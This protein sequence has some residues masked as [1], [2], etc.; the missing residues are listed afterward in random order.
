MNLREGTRRLALLLS[1]SC[2]LVIFS[3][4]QA[5]SGQSKVSLE[6]GTVTVWLGMPQ[7]QAILDLQKAGYK[8]FGQ[9]DTRTVSIGNS[10]AMIGFKN[11]RLAYATREWYSPGEDEMVA[12]VNA[13]TAL[14]SYSVAPCS[15]NHQDMNNPDGT[16]SIV[17][18]NCG[19]RSLMFTK[20]EAQTREG[21]EAVIEVQERIGLK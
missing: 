21:R 19:E 15:L 8:V 11:G 20:G 1:A 6:V 10:P 9:G 16:A 12:V 18:L 4:A 14:A 5:A 7:S 17:F 3:H 13:L 2:V